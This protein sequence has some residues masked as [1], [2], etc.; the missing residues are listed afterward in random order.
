MTAMSFN[1]L[2]HDLGIQY[3]VGGTW[4]LYQNFP[5]KGFTKTRTFY[6]LSGEAIIHSYW[7][8]RGR[9]FL[10]EVLDAVGIMPLSE[11]EKLTKETL[12]DEQDS[13]E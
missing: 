7:T 3:K 8:Q 2:L 4:V 13:C 5:N 11:L 6:K 10:Y 12:A 1:L 9:R